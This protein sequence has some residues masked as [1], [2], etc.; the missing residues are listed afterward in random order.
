MKSFAQTTRAI[1]DWTDHLPYQN[2][3][4]VTQSDTKIIFNTDLSI[5]TIDK[6]DLSRQTLSKQDGLSDIGIAQIEYDGFN[7]QLI[8]AYDNSN[9]DLFT[10]EQVINLPNILSNQNISGDR[11]IYDIHVMDE[12][13]ILLAVGFGIVE[14][15]S[16]NAEFG[17]TTTALRINAISSRD[18]IMYAGTD[19]GFYVF[20]RS[21]PGFEGDFNN[22]DLL[23]PEQGL[24]SVYE[25]VDI[26]KFNGRIYAILD[27]EL[28]MEDS[29]QQFKKIL[30]P[31]TGFRFA[32]ISADGEHLLIGQR[33]DA[34]SSNTILINS[35][36]QET[37]IE[38]GCINNTI[39]GVEDENGR[40][41]YA[42]EWDLI[43]FH[44]SISGGCQQFAFDSPF[45]EEI[46]DIEIKNNSIY[47]ASGGV[48]DNLT[49]TFSRDGNYIFE[50]NDWTNINQ[51]EFSFFRNEDILNFFRI[52]PDPINDVVYMGTYWAGLVA[53]N[54]EN[55][56]IQV[57]N[58]NNSTLQGAVGDEQRERVSGLIFDRNNNLWI[59][60][61]GAPEPISVLTPEGNWH[62]FDVGSNTSLTNVVIDDFDNKWFPVF[63]NNGGVLVF[64]HGD[65]IEDPTDDQ[66]K[67]INVS[68]SELTTNDINDIE[69]D[70]EGSVWVATG[71]GPVIF[72]CGSD[73][74]SEECTG[75][76]IRVLQDSIAAFLL[77]DVSIN[78]IEVD[79]ANRKW[80]GT[81]NGI[82]VQNASGDEQELGFTSD[83]SPLFDDNI[84][85][86]TFDGVTG[87][88][89]IGSD[90]GLQVYRT[91]TTTARRIH[92]SNVIS[93]PNPVPPDYT[94]PIGIKGLAN[95][96]NVKI[97]DI[98]GKLVFETNS[99]GGQALWDGRD[100]RGEK[101]STGVY[102]VFSSTTNIF[103]DPDSFVSKIMIVR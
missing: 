76:R 60:N 6:E 10:N 94:G 62:S 72:D 30:A 28:W 7:D 18:N 48:S 86:L 35:S 81:N 92:S 26:T 102:L 8:I 31:D 59:A 97:T 45:S 67:F 66:F 9:L 15:R 53:F 70:L 74:F 89:W 56:E 24:P 88:M 64:N 21:S 20:D 3:R 90:R 25:V 44:E 57:Y 73:P 43:R 95:D 85:E 42:D 41:W 51:F 19:D 2:S 101:V 77:A 37:R 63:G 61:F 22:W 75:R 84:I 50:N 4:W 87:D 68:N 49:Y 71:E 32:Y 96:V 99:F 103:D 16:Q 29:D 33:N 11:S 27:G 1:G 54:E 52:Q 5:F 39:Y 69:V 100:F 17:F 12:E 79:G 14:I 98:N 46:S 40:I 36:G 55:Q 93:F 34:N 65:R 91:K 38:D 78:T 58:Q 80:F 13:S 47:V 23:G 83:N 82:F